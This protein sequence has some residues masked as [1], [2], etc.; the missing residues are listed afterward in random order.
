M[1]IPILNSTAWREYRGQ[2][3][4]AGM[5]STHIATISDTSGFE[6]LC[7]VKLVPDPDIPTLLCEAMGWVLAGHA[8]L[9]RPPF[10]AIV[11]VDIAKLHKSQ[12]LPSNLVNSGNPFC[13]AWC[14]QAL[15]GKSLRQPNMGD[16]VIDRKAF[17]RAMDSRKIAAFDEWTNLRDR[18]LGNVIKMSKGGYGVIDNETMLYDYI[19]PKTVPLNSNRLIEH[20]K[21]ALDSKDYKRF[22]VEMANAA[23][24]HTGAL[25]SAEVDLESVLKLI[26]PSDLTAKAT[27]V[28]LLEGRCKDDW[29]EKQ[30]KVMA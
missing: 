20:A 30:L 1:P 16:L 15:A 14:S 21:S 17:L 9:T 2:P 3:G 7:F 23:K 28:S 5:N 4:R 10:V 8:G 11:M 26:I 22:K 13:V 19:W 25:A 6:R 27:I 12:A 29:L 24:G 18:N